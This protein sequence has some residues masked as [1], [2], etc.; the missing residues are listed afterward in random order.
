MG[1]DSS[2]DEDFSENTFAINE[3]ELPKN[4][5]KKPESSFEILSMDKIVQDVFDIV[6]NVQTFLAVRISLFFLIYII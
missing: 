2:Y 5:T 1:D 6:M 4:E 3:I